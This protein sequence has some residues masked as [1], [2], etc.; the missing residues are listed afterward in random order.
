[1]EYSLPLL[2]KL[3]GACLGF[4][5][6]DIQGTRTSLHGRNRFTKMDSAHSNSNNVETIYTQIGIVQIRN[7]Q[8]VEIVPLHIKPDRL[9]N[10]IVIN[11]QHQVVL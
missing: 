4:E 5:I 10:Y 3:D 11:H 7:L 8:L 1:M 2:Q 9:R 6:N